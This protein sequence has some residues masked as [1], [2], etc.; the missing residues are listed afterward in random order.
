MR[1][2]SVAWICYNE[3]EICVFNKVVE[4]VQVTIVINIHETLVTAIL[5]MLKEKF[6]SIIMTRGKKH[7]YLG[8][9]Y[10]L[11]CKSGVR[12]SIVKCGENTLDDLKVNGVATSP[13]T[14]GLFQ[15][16][17]TIGENWKD[18]SSI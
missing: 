12:I 1:K 5:D 9:I 15:S 14:D 10:D 13:V 2:V 3:H 4:G 6:G 16:T 7:E 18:Y 17:I 8:M 11:Q